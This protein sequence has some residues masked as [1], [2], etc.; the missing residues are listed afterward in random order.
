MTAL[1]LS[2]EDLARFGVEPSDE[3]AHAYDPD[4]EWWNESWFWD[5]Y[6]AEGRVAGHCRIGMHPNQRRAWVWLYLKHGDEWLCIEEPRLP[7]S[8]FDPDR[9]AYDG[10]GLRFS[11]DVASPIRTGRFRFEGFGR[12]LSGPRLGTLQAC[13]VDL[14]VEAM[15]PPHAPN[16]MVAGHG[17][18]KYPTSRFEQPVSYRGA[19][20]IGTDSQALEAR[21]ERDHSWGPRMWNMEWTVLVLNGDTLRTMSAVVDIP[22]APRIP[23]G[24]LYR[25]DFEGLVEVEHDLEVHG[26]PVLDPVA[27][28]FRLKTDGGHELRGE[29]ECISGI[30]IDITHCFEPPQRSL[31]RRGLIR[32]HI[33]GQSDPMIGWLEV[34]RL[35]PEASA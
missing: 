35:K 18:Q 13:S 4:V 15:G 10:W 5:W 19:T 14:E 6:D 34:N 27:G 21:G 24:Y 20:R 12:M 2:D 25:K 28:K 26:R 17:S 22:G 7:L 31:Y 8:S 30:E 16:K 9:L 11:W 23:T 3:G 1:H 32:A 33:E 29:I